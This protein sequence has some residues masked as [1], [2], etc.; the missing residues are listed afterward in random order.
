[1]I[2]P[3]VLGTLLDTLCIALLNPYH[4]QIDNGINH[5]VQKLRLRKDLFPNIMPLISCVTLGK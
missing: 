3:Y 5:I 1:M 2:T 4:T